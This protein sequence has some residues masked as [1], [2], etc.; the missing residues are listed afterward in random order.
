MS[1]FFIFKDVLGVGRALTM[2]CSAHTETHDVSSP[3][4][5]LCMSSGVG[6]NFAQHAFFF[7]P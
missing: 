1:D 6:F 2:E 3:S 5:H 4:S 7:T